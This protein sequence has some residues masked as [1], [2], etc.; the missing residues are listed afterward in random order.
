VGCGTRNNCS[1]VMPDCYRKLKKGRERSWLSAPDA[2][3]YNRDRSGQRMIKNEK[4]PVQ[5]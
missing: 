5:I 4:P 3:H 2:M 1:I